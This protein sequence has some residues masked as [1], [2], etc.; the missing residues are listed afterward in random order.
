LANV[1]VYRRKISEWIFERLGVRITICVFKC[2]RI[3]SVN[4]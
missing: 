3:R 1:I 4:L 2:I